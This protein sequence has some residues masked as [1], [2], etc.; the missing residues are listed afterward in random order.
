MSIGARI[1]EERRR[2]KFSQSDFA[3]LG[4]ASKSSQLSW[5]QGRAYPD[6]RVLKAWFEA[7]VDVGYIVTDVRAPLNEREQNLIN[8]FR[9]ANERRQTLIEMDAFSAAVHEITGMTLELINGTEKWS[10][11]NFFDNNPGLTF[12]KKKSG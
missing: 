3:A 8:N 12:N 10:V 1:K 9:Q 7:G 4:N 11:Q 6:A 2:L 5:E